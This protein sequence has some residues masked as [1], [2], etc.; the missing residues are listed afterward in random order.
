MK[1][2]LLILICFFLLS[3]DEEQ[4]SEIDY[5]LEYRQ[6]EFDV[7]YKLNK[8]KVSKFTNLNIDTT[9]WNIGS[10]SEVYNWWLLRMGKCS[11]KSFNFHSKRGD[12]KVWGGMDFFKKKCLITIEMFEVVNPIFD[13]ILE[14][15]TIPNNLYSFKY[16]TNRFK[17]YESTEFIGDVNIKGLI[18]TLPKGFKYNEIGYFT[19]IEDCKKYQ[20][21]IKTE[22][23]YETFEC[24]N[25]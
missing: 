24:K 25:K 5:D 14:K 8:T 1:K 9:L 13:L 4:T 2:L 18:N 19:N 11:P 7:K 20:K 21:R 3:C 23:K 15:K 12:E 16:I 6:S 10:P 17:Y 22:F